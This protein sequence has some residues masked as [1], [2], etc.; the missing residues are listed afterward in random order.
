M[1]SRTLGWA[2]GLAGAAVVGRSLWRAATACNFR[3]KVVLVT[4]GSRGLGLV[5]A[6]RFGAEG[7]IVAIAARDREEIGRALHDLHQR[8]CQAAGWIADLTD[9]TEARGL[10]RAVVDRFGRLDV[11]VNN[12]GVIQVGPLESMSLNDFHDALDN[13]FWSAV[14]AVDA[15]LPELRRTRGRIVNIASIGGKVAVPHLLPY[16]A[17]KFA[18]VG[19]SQGLRAELAKDGIVVTTI[20]PGLMRTGSHGHAEFKGQ[21]RREYALFSTVGSLPFVSISAESAAAA[22]LDACR[23]GDAEAILGLSAQTASLLSHLLPGLT[24][25]CLSLVAR[26]LPAARDGDRHQDPIPG[27]ESHSEW[28][29]SVLTRP[30][31]EAAVRNNETVAG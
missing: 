28:A 12:A 6:R 1:K 13:D 20:C 7:A 31:E 23:H 15:S 5:L 10:A 24:S 19:Y 8:G 3:N 30:N 2:I 11:L 26:A 18:L 17:A 22:I 25:A 4:G 16:C 21:H 9:P 27:S 14:H 29:P